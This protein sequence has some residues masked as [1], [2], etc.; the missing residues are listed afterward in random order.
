[1]SSK[2][3]IQEY[4]L[5]YIWHP[6]TQMKEYQESPIVIEDSDGVYLI[7]SDGKKYIDG[8]SSL[9]VNIHG[10][11]SKEINNAIKQQIDKIAHSTLL[12]ITNPSALY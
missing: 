2:S 1:M 7:D 8:V 10:H 6:F 12:G 4:D 3:K 9:W 11:K 5:K